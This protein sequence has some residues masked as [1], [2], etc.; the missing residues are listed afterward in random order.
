[1]PP[2]VFQS[3]SHRMK[4]LMFR[5]LISHSL[6]GSDIAG[7]TSTATGSEGRRGA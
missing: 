2:R 3:Y 4:S 7:R 1:M 6:A 5:E